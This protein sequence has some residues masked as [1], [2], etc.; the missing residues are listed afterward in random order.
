M[1]QN[2]REGMVSI[3]MPAYNCEKFIQQSIESVLKQSY[4]NLELI[5]IDDCS[6]DKTGLKCLEYHDS[7]I[8]YYRQHSNGGCAKARNKGIELSKGEYIAFLD[9]DDFW[10]VNKLEK[11]IASLSYNE[12]CFTA[13]SIIDNLNHVIKKRAVS[14]HLMMKDMLAENSIIFS[15]VV[16]RYE[17]IKNIVF[18]Q[19]WY[20]EDYIFL[21]DCL[22]QGISLHG[23][24]ETLC[25]YRV[26][27]GGRSFNK[28]NA[29]KHRW[30]IYRQ[31]LNMNLLKSMFYF[32]QYAF[33]GVKKYI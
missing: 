10:E 9:S 8:S 26:H 3:I 22:K 17:D 31:Y 14:K 5:I 18:K 19:K 32:V 23:I 33:Y 4:K 28:Q 25:N 11:Q 24:N 1:K 29:A 30:I 21:L 2:R 7:R 27:D 15:T 6:T 20:H 16:C 12:L 13:Y